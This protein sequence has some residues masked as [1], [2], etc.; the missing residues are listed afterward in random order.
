ML[1]I[2]VMVSDVVNDDAHLPTWLKSNGQTS[3]YLSFSFPFRGPAL[4]GAEQLPEKTELS[5]QSWILLSFVRRWLWRL[6][7]L[8]AQTLDFLQNFSATADKY[9]SVNIVKCFFFFFY[10]CTVCIFMYP[11]LKQLVAINWVYFKRIRIIKMC[12]L[13]NKHMLT[14]VFYFQRDWKQYQWLF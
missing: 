5:Q 2:C 1:H 4:S 11:L 8:E 12:L 9:K 7:M 6:L 14:L 10:F 3:L 13:L